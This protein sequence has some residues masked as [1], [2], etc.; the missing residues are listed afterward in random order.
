MNS[1]SKEIYRHDQELGENKPA[2]QIRFLEL[3]L[4]KL[5]DQQAK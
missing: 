3:Q 4:L 5:L 2:L 1:E